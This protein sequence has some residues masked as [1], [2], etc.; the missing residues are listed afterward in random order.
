MDQ[1]HGE[2]VVQ[3]RRT[4]GTALS[5]QGISRFP[6]IRDLVTGCFVESR[7]SLARRSLCEETMGEI[8]YGYK[9]CRGKLNR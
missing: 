5:A 7:Q 2:G 6:T 9:V 4:D 1:A 3:S 8:V